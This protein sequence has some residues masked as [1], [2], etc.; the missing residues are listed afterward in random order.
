MVS[1]VFFLSYL[2][3][4]NSGLILLNVNHSL[5]IFQYHPGIFCTI[6]FFTPNFFTKQYETSNLEMFF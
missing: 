5:I 1:K 4:Y 2:I 3:V 6:V